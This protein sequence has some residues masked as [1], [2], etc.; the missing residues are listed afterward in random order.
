MNTTT[1]LIMTFM[2]EVGKKVS[3]SVDNPRT[4]ISEEDIS[5]VMTL[6]IAKDVFVPNGTSLASMVD[7]KVVTTDV[8]EYEIV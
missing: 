2:T 7:A 6:I 8:T 3:L 1:R 4:N 5:D